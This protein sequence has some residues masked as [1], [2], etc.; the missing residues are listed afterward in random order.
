MYDLALIFKFFSFLLFVCTMGGLADF[1]F[2]CYD[3]LYCVKFFLR[4]KTY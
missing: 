2:V 4:D 3:K 1:S